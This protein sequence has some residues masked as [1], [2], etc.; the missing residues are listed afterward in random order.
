MSAQRP[1]EQVVDSDS[2]QLVAN[3]K[4]HHLGK[5]GV[6]Y[7]RLR[8]Q[9]LPNGDVYPM[10]STPDAASVL[11]VEC[12]A[13]GLIVGAHFL[14]QE[15]PESEGVITKA[16]GGYCNLGETREEAAIRTLRAKMGIVTEVKD[17]IPCGEAY[18]YGDQYRFPVSCYVS[19]AFFV[20]QDAVLG[21]GCKRRFMTI[22]EVAD[23]HRKNRFFSDDTVHL[24]ATIMLRNAM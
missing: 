12:D 17:L 2:V 13:A 14:C 24:I 16:V 23:T 11:P 5:N 19:K 18:G 6:P 21:S 10:I 3:Q 22:K 4:F 15:R 1:M 8:V 20:D 9:R 7:F